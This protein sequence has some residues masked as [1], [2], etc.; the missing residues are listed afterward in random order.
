MAAGDEVLRALR[1]NSQV[2]A[3]VCRAD[4][5]LYGVR[6]PGRAGGGLGAEVDEVS[7]LGMGTVDGQESLLKVE[8]SWVVSS[9]VL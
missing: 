4:G 6:D 8:R 7:A 3:G 9:Q 5:M 2:R 1:N